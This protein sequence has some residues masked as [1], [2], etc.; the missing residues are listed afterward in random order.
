MARNIYYKV[1]ERTGN[2]ITDPEWEEI[3]RLQ[4]WYNSEFIWTAGKLMFK[5]HVIF[6]N[7]E[8]EPDEEILFRMILRRRSELREQGHLDNDI[9]RLLESEGLIISKR[10]GYLDN[11]LASGFTRVA[12]NEWNA[13]LVC[14]FLLKASSVARSCTIEVFD[15]GQFVKPRSVRMRQGSIAI[16]SMEAGR[17]SFYRALV[18]NRRVFSVVDP[19][20]Y[21][22]F[23]VYENTVQDFNDRDPEE[24]RSLVKDLN[25]L[26]FENNF[27]LNGDDIQGVDLNRKVAGFDAENQ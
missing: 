26:G 18:S 27:D 6:P 7:L 25:W 1:L 22:Q 2:S 16:P 20:K 9:I 21:D 5:M 17:E 19:A 4:H 13:Y 12:A 24:R 8:H 15:E 23:P 14:E 10:G 11:C 3:L